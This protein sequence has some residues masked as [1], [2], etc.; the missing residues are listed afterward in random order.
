MPK[1]VRPRKPRPAPPSRPA[2]AVRPDGR[3]KVRPGERPGVP[4]AAMV[5]AV[6]AERL[7]WLLVLLPPL[8][9]VPAAREAFRLPK[10]LVAEWLALASLIPLAWQRARRPPAP[11]VSGRDLLRH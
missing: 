8:L 4:P 9:V 2:A 6:W 10:L 5:R 11:A 7:L 3:S 1:P